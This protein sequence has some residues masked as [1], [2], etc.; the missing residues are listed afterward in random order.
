MR[1]GL[2]PHPLGSFGWYDTS[3]FASGS[4]LSSFSL[5]CHSFLI[6]F[7]S[8]RALIA[9]TIGVA[10]LCASTSAIHNDSSAAGPQE[11]VGVISFYYIVTDSVLV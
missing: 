8:R 10:S 4:Y 1:S 6:L 2:P 9:S 5:F 7:Q 3:R 11:K